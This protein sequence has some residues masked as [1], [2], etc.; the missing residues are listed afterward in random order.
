MGVGSEEI[1]LGNGSA[2]FDS[3]PK[4]RAKAF[5]AQIWKRRANHGRPRESKESQCGMRRLPPWGATM[6]WSRMS[7]GSA[8]S[9]AEKLVR[10]G[11]RPKRVD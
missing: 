11:C 8:V 10:S 1:Q 7:S 5:T 9:Y 2:P 3:P 4:P 6:N